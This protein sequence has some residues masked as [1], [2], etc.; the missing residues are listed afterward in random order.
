MISL[1][2][3]RVLIVEDTFLVADSLRILIEAYGATVAAMVPSNEKA[4]AAL[5][6]VEID[7]AILD[8]HLQDGK[9][10]PFAQHL[11]KIGTPFL[12]VTGYGEDADI[13]ESLA[14]ITRL[15]KPLQIERLL[16]ALAPL[17][18]RSE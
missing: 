8:I 11:L 13:P 10:Y 9:V 1:K 7:V 2:G 14:S 3:T 12:F 18:G 6:E 15:E 5:E 4:F 16:R 17:L